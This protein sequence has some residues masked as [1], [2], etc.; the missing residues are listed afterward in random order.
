MNST[1]SGQDSR[2]GETRRAFIKKAAAAAAVASATN[3]FKTP[4]YG[5]NQAP[6]SG[7]VIGAN[8][9]IT[10]GYVGV[11]KQGT[12]HL[13][14]QKK[15]ATDNN[16]AQVAVCDLYQKH[17]DAARQAIGVKESDAYSDH[18]KLLERKD[19]DAIV[20]APVDNWHA[21]VTIDSLE[22]GKHVFCEKPMTRYLGEAFQV[23]DTVKKSGKVYVIGSQGCM[24]SKWHKA[25]EWIRAGKLGPLVWSQGSYC[26]NNKN[27]DEWGYAV[28]PDASE[29]NLDWK[30]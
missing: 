1:S 8:D 18:R 14:S 9:R 7:R 26:R 11:G 5:Q 13:L 16:I 21:Q 30:R 27:N 15:F 20:A 4:V 17:L 19:I 28:D 29:K 12:V 23:Y 2:V 25:A 6:S 3:I 24:D 22:A 10:V